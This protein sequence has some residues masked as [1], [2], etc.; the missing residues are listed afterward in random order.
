[1]LNF[2]VYRNGDIVKD[3]KKAG[4]FV[5]KNV[6]GGGVGPPFGRHA[7]LR[8]FHLVCI[9]IMQITINLKSKKNI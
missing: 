2:I 7:A 4:S 3:P 9:V 8:L 5:A 1:M 6:P